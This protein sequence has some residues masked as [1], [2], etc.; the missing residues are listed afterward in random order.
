MTRK[1]LL[2][3]AITFFVVGGPCMPTASA[4]FIWLEAPPALAR[5]S[6]PTVA[7]YFGEYQEFLREEAGG[8][9]DKMD[10]TKAWVVDPK[11]S[12]QELSLG[13]KGSRF[14][15]VLNQPCLPGRYQVL[16]EHTELEVQDLTKRDL[17][18]AKPHFHA[19]TQFV[20]ADDSWIG[21]REKEIAPTGGLDILLLTK[22]IN[23]ARGELTASLGTEMLVKIV[24][25]GAPLVSQ[26]FLVHS[27]LGWNKEI[28][29]DSQGIASFTPLW[30]GRY[31]LELL[32]VEKASG[33][34][35]GKAYQTIRHRATLTLEI[36]GQRP[37]TEK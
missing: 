17:G 10:G 13:K 9:L 30:P 23:L 37:S 11:G 12:R 34:F 31:V 25:K 5:N 24:F 1:T 6:E 20:C 15:G 27:P 28:K 21:E 7:L 3:I 32:H 18:I 16:A 22:G 14:V 2:S 29:T 26:E 36:A 33:E 4:H 19:R 35:N 8:R